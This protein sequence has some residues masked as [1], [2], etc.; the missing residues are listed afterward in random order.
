[1]KK[2]LTL[3]IDEALLQKARVFAAMENT[4]V[5]EMIRDFLSRTVDRA[6]EQDAVTNKL[7]ELSR[8][9]PGRIGDYRP[10]RSETYSGEPRFDRFR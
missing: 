6:G 4:S 9:T 8:T 3:S 1:M 7:L 2:N 5:N 10:S